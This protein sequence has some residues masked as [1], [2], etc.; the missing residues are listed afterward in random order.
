MVFAVAS[1]N[2]IVGFICRGLF[3]GLLPPLGWWTLWFPGRMNVRKKRFCIPKC[4]TRGLLFQL[5]QQHWDRQADLHVRLLVKWISA[6]VLRW[7]RDVFQKKL[8]RGGPDAP[9]RCCLMTWCPEKMIAPKF[10][11][12]PPTSRPPLG[13]ELGQRGHQILMLIYNFSLVLA[14][15]V[16]HFG[17]VLFSW[18]LFL[19][20]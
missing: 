8:R 2:S 18:Q 11:W 15:K 7:S 10:M 12:P 4:V 9:P 13:D 1:S 20:V 17:A 5:H 19:L 14:V 16:S 3:I 6:F